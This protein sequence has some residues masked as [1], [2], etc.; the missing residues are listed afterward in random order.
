MNGHKTPGVFLG[1]HDDNR[2]VSILHV[3]LRAMPLSYWTPFHA[4]TWVAS[5]SE[6]NTMIGLRHHVARV[7]I[8]RNVYETE[9]TIKESR[10]R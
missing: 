5:D 2:R 8:W 6:I 1:V 4:K 7:L 10:L 3:A 9:S